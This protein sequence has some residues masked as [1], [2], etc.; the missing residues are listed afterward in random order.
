VEIFGIINLWNP[1]GVVT[2]GGALVLAFLLGI[3]HGITPDEH[4]WPITF[5]YAIGSY[6]SRK[7]LMAGLTF[8]AAFTLQRA[9]ASELAAIALGK[10]FVETPWLDYAVYVAVGV[11]MAIAARYLFRGEHW[12]LLSPAH[13]VDERV[14][15]VSMKPWMPAVHG[16]IAGWG[17]GAFALILYTVLA[18]AMP[19]WLGWAPGA[20][21][22]IGTTIVQAL[23]GALFGSMAR[24]LSLSEA[25]IRGVAVVTAGRTLLFGGVAFVIAG[26]I[27]LAF[28]NLLGFHIVTPLHVHNLHNIGI[29]QVLVIFSV[30][31]VGIGTLV[32]ETRHAARVAR[33]RRSEVADG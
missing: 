26:L 2:I 27:G 14:P 10:V 8:S 3:V 17:V 5:S 23:A 21:F 13:H 19:V 1:T 28:P 9:I 20:A 33:E 16:F 24:H 18:P 31:V 30:V 22:G 11:A 4:T 15:E 7:G 12:H 29:A 25:Q 6:S 32:R